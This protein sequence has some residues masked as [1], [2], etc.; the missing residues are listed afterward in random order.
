MGDHIH[1]CKSI[2]YQR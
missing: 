1:M 2:L